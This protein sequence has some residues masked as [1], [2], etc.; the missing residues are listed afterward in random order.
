MDQLLQLA[1]IADRIGSLGL[2]AVLIAYLTWLRWQQ[3]KSQPDP[4]AERR[5]GMGDVLIELRQHSQALDRLERE[6]GVIATT[7][8]IIRARQG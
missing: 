2:A 3:S 8:A 5:A 6:Q 1:E 4:T 7:V